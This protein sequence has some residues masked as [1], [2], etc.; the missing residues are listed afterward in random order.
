M[1]LIEKISSLK[2]GLSKEEYRN[3]FS[4]KQWV[5]YH[6]EE[7]NAI[8]FIEI[9]DD[10]YTSVSAFFIVDDNNAYKLVEI[11][12]SFYKTDYQRLNDKISN[13]LFKKNKN[14]LTSIY[15]E[16]IHIDEHIPEELYMSEFISWKTEKSTVT[17][18]LQLSEDYHS[19]FLSK[20]VLSDISTINTPPSVGIVIVDTDKEKE[21]NDYIVNQSYAMKQTQSNELEKE[22]EKLY[23]PMFQKTMKMSLSQ[24][25]NIFSDM[26]N[27]AKKRS[28]ESDTV[29]LPNNYGDIILE[30][31]LTNKK[32]KLSLDRKRAEGVTDEDIKWWWNIPDLTRSMMLEMDARTKIATLYGLM[33]KGGFSEEEAWKKIPKYCP[34]FGDPHDSGDSDNRYDP[35][36]FE[37]KNKV[38]SYIEKRAK[39]NPEQFRKEMENSPN[40]NFLVRK[41]IKKNNL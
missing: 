18:R 9:N 22:L 38:N 14:Y 8:T 2:W 4:D 20:N 3:V 35:L 6:P 34:V 10:V 33:E 31:E 1:D 28:K 25:Q 15:G 5:D 41:E 16:P 13:D 19:L 23:V 32:I 12:L 24:A 30:E 21:I 26:L 39:T 7:K 37:L 29:N 40:F 11:F 17:L 27:Q 36:P